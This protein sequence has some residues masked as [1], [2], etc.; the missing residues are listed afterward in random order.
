M[1]VELLT[2]SLNNIL[3]SRGLGKKDALNFFRGT[4]KQVSV[5]LEIWIFA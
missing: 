5:R 2:L 4:Y 1:T 3:G